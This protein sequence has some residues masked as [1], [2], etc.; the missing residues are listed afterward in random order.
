MLPTSLFIVPVCRHS[1]VITNK[2]ALQIPCSLTVAAVSHVYRGLR[3]LPLGS[4]FAHIPAPRPRALKPRQL[5]RMA[6]VSLE[7]IP[8]DATIQGGVAWRGRSARNC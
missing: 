4:D 5:F 3:P 1:S 2:C 8:R 7:R 6:D